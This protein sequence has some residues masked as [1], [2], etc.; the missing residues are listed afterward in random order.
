MNV[1]IQAQRK[2]LF[3]LLRKGW[4]NEEERLHFT[5]ELFKYQYQFNIVYR[6]Y[7]HN[8]GKSPENVMTRSQIPY[9]PISAF[10]FHKVISG[11][12]SSN[13]V[14]TSSGT[15]GQ[16]PSCH[17]VSDLDFYLNHTVNIWKKEFDDV[18]NY[19]FLALLPG[20]LERQGSSLIAM[21]QHYINNSKYKESGFYLYDHER[22]IKQLLICKSL[23]IPTVLWGVTHSLY[24]F[25]E[26][27]TI[28]FPGLL[29]ME[30]GGMK[31]QKQ[32]ISKKEFHNLLNEKWHVSGIYS[33]YGMTELMSQ[34]YTRGGTTF[35]NNDYLEIHTHQVNDPLCPEKINKPGIIC[36]TDLANIDSCAFIQTE[37]MGIVRPDGQFEILGRVDASEWRGCNLLVVES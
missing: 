2:N 15:T 33:E 5:M 27:Y 13:T 9:L 7:C 35:V 3:D 31:G 24:D 32:E 18:Q 37:D 11:D 14:F 1:D 34:A 21:M 16:I 17:Y 19:C 28:D 12:I 36:L 25:S 4:E 26:K 6:E 30:T 10:K 23:D 20:Y 29:V 22:L 8:L